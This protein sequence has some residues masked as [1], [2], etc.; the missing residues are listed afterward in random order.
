MTRS[1]SHATNSPAGDALSE[2][3][4]G[5]LSARRFLRAMFSRNA[6]GN[7]CDTGATPAPEHPDQQR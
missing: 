7:T 6:A 3:Q 4:K 5:V 1:I 2:Y